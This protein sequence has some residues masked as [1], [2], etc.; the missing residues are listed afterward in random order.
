M[1]LVVSLV[2]LFGWKADIP[3]DMSSR[4]ELQ[5]AVYILAPHTSFWDFFIGLAC[6]KKMGIKAHIFIKKEFFNWFT[7]PFLRRWGGIAVDRGN[8]KNNLVGKAVDIFAKEQRFVTIIC[9]EGTRK[10]VKRWKHGFYEIAQQAHVP[11]V[12]TYIDYRTKRMGVG[13]SYVP[14]GDYQQDMFRYMAFYQDK[15]GRHPEKF[16]KQANGYSN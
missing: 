12:C 3:D 4:P 8:T 9:P 7:S 13:P 6:V 10:P 11:V 5:R 15:T 2:G 14:T 16:N 1:S